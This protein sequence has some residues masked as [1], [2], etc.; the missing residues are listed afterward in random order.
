MTLA[1]RFA[2]ALGAIIVIGAS[3]AV[4][5]DRADSSTP[6]GP[7]PV[8]PPI[9][10]SL[11]AGD[12]HTCAI[13]DG[14]VWCT[15]LNSEGQLGA[16]TRARAIAFSPSD[17]SGAVRVDAG[18]S[19]TCAIRTDA[20]LWCWGLLASTTTGA[21][22]L[23]TV[24]LAPSRAPVQVPLDAVTSVAVGGSHT[25][26]LRSDGTVWCWGL[27]TTGQLGDGTSVSS[28]VPVRAAIDAVTSLDAGPSHTCAVRVDSSL[29]CWGSNR[30]HRLGQRAGD[31]RTVPTRVKDLSVRS[32][33]T[34]GAF[35]C[36]ITTAGAVACWGRNN[37][38]QVG[39]RAGASRISPFTT[40]VR[41]AESLSAGVEFVCAVI[42]R[43]VAGRA[44]PVRSTPTPVRSTWCWGR[45][46]DGQLADGSNR[47]RYLPRQIVAPATVGRLSAVAAGSSH[48]CGLA[49]RGGALWCWGNGT[50]GQLGD[51]ATR[52]R[53]RGTAIWPNDVQMSPIGSDQRATVVATGDIVCDMDRRALRGVGP[54]GPECGEIFTS[55]LVDHLSPDAVLALGDLQ[56]ENADIGSFRDNWSWTWGRHDARTYPV[57][58]NHEYLD[59]GA[60]GYVGW[61]GAMS[62]SYWWAD[63]GGWRLLAIDSWCQGQLFAGCSASSP[64]TRWLAAQLARARA[65]GRCAAVMMHHPIISSGRHGTDSVRPLWQTIVAGGADLVLTAHDHLYERFEPLGSD[66]RP[67]PDGVPLFIS[68]LGG[69]PAHGFTDIEPGSA[70]R[71]N[72][73]HGVL[74]MTFTPTN[75][76]WS[77][78]SAKDGSVLDSGSTTCT[79]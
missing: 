16:G 49:P 28:H 11:T 50:Q 20:T 59:A 70:A 8:D 1:R 15:G 48:A 34:G 17:V 46:R 13:R 26:A 63:M 69:A 23:P 51:G 33:A 74:S 65:E 67:S 3:L 75:V 43:S 60:A 76:E 56:Y 47:F 57:R 37:F 18:G 42:A 52:I 54:S 79:P 40:T 39:K 45:N 27:N 7:R 53:R 62:P 58:G 12:Q 77:F 32:V 68:G 71:V 66:A 35:T 44:T 30:Y 36:A 6:P 25:C 38:G 31:R 72:D 24:V 2:G 14:T 61:F 64:Q 10:S 19:T 5:G 78:V 22:L 21:D 4:P 41:N 73:V 9:L 29:W 55:L